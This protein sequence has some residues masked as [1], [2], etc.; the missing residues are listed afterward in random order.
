[1][2]WFFAGLILINLGFWMWASWYAEPARSRY[3]PRPRPEVNAQ[4]I[5]L[6]TEQGVVL[7]PRPADRQ[8]ARALTDV[9]PPKRCFVIGSFATQDGARQARSTLASQGL[10]AVIQEQ[11]AP[12]TVYRVYIPPLSSVR[13]AEAM[14]RKLSRLG[15]DDHAVIKEPGLE[16][17]VSLGVFS[18]KANADAQ[19]G[20]LGKKGI[21][22]RSQTLSRPITRHALMVK[23]EQ[24]LAAILERQ[25]WG[26]P[27][28]AIREAECET[29]AARARTPR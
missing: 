27:D 12:T 5:R 29:P 26:S 16:N 3:A 20:K 1:M 6:V 2:K 13:D 23:S 25:A 19:L 22:A 28:V 4:K 24:D 9:A 17:A 15:F 8:P 18:V 11:L 10:G 14:R 21:T 7:K